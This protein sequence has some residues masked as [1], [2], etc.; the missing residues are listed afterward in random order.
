MYRDGLGLVLE[1]W[2]LCQEKVLRS[3]IFWI[4]AGHFEERFGCIFLGSILFVLDWDCWSICS[5]GWAFLL[6]ICFW[7]V[8]DTKGIF[9]LLVLHLEQGF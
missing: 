9:F 2:I 4:L 7:L 3:N 5:I 1:E 6:L 8:R